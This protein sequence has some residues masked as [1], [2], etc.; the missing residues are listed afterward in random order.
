MLRIDIGPQRIIF[1]SRAILQLFHVV[2]LLA[3]YPSELSVVA[4][5]STLST[6]EA[7]CELKVILV[8]TVSSRTAWTTK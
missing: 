3:Q 1:D 7:C 4:H 5:I 8:Y 6:W 2:S